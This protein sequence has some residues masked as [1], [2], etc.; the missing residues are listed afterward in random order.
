MCAA[1]LIME[2]HAVVGNVL[3]P[4]QE[5]AVVTPRVVALPAAIVTLMDA[6]VQGIQVATVQYTGVQDQQSI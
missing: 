5:D 4:A 1:A 2:P 6:A 3:R